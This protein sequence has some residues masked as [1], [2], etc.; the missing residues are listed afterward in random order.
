M[1]HAAR[2]GRSKVL[3]SRRTVDTRRSSRGSAAISAETALP[4]EL[5]RAI[6]E[7]Q[8]LRVEASAALGCGN[9]FAEG[10]RALR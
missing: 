6:N 5:G 8:E 7:A 4:S 1:F 2:A 10:F 3:A 9:R